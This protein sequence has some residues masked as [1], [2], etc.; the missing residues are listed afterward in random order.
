MALK[1]HVTDMMVTSFAL[2]KN[3]LW[4][5]YLSSVSLGTNW[6]CISKNKDGPFSKNKE[7]SS[8]PCIVQRHSKGAEHFFLKKIPCLPPSLCAKAVFCLYHIPKTGK[9]FAFQMEPISLAD[10]L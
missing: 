9:L 6:R 1:V 5:P 2:K 10:T 4:E 7:V 8:C 3:N